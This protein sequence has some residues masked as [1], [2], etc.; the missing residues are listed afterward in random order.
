MPI[1]IGEGTLVLCFSVFFIVC[2]PRSSYDV[3]ASNLWFSRHYLILPPLCLGTSSFND[4]LVFVLGSWAPFD[5]F[6]QLWPGLGPPVPGLWFDGFG[7][8]WC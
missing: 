6:I 3:V 8:L 2:H 5:I 4:I 1:A 7:L